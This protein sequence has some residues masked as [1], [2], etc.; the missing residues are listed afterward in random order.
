MQHYK[1]MCSLQPLY[2]V[3]LLKELYNIVLIVELDERDSARRISRTS[4]NVNSKK[5]YR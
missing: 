4:G 2:E 5:L 1:F 3:E